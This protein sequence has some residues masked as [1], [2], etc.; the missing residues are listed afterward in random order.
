MFSGCFQELRNIR[1]HVVTLYLLCYAECMG[2]ST[3]PCSAK[4][5]GIED[6]V[7][8]ARQAQETL[9]TKDIPSTGL[10]SQMK[11]LPEGDWLQKEHICGIIS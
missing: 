2:L 7:E 8:A 10:S 5:V 4:A 11:M 1:V 6:A 3:P 9:G